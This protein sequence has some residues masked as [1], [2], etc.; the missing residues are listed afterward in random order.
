MAI[1]IVI[2]GSLAGCHGRFRRACCLIFMMSFGVMI[3]QTSHWISSLKNLIHLWN[4][5]SRQ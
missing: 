4:E 5:N 3:M 1:W 2:V